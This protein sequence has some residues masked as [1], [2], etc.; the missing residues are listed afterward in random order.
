VVED[1]GIKDLSNFTEKTEDQKLKDMTKDF[2]AEKNGEDYCVWYE[3]ESEWFIGTVKHDFRRVVTKFGD[4][5]VTHVSITD[6][7][8][9]SIWLDVRGK[10]KGGTKNAE[11]LEA[12]GC[13]FK[14]KE[15]FNPLA[16]Q[17]R[18]KELLCLWGKFFVKAEEKIGVIRFRKI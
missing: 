4:K 11:F 2:G 16:M 13:S 7:K 5:Y 6:D 3:G 15:K 12:L 10:V 1:P 8:E 14:D 18:G 17:I 9:A